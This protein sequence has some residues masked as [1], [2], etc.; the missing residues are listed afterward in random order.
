M[1][2][3]AKKLTPINP[4][5]LKTLGEGTIDLSKYVEEEFSQVAKAIQSTEP[6][7]VWNRPPPR[8]R[9]GTTAY[10]DGTNWNP[11]NGEGPYWFDGTS[12]HLMI[13]SGAWTPY[14][15]VVGA[16]GGGTFGSVAV[17]G[18]YV[19]MGRVVNITAGISIT[20][21]GSAT[22][23]VTLSIPFTS[24][25]NGYYTLSGREV[26]TT[27]WMLQGIVYPSTSYI[28]II[29]YDNSIVLANGYALW[30]SGIYESAA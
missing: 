21:I 30:V 27:G 3:T 16:S 22:G 19:K 11:G 4:S 15:P 20:S 10:A 9:R 24:T 14:A 12:W 13:P 28:V 23:Y 6:D 7:T 25:A 26:N 18:R 29:R 2:F 8:P 1:P 17:S 5:S